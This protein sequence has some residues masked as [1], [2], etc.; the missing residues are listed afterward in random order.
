MRQEKSNGKSGHQIL[1][2]IEAGRA[3]KMLTRLV[4]TSYPNSPSEEAWK[5]MFRIFPELTEIS[6]DF[7]QQMEMCEFIAAWLRKA[8]DAGRDLRRFEWFAWQAQN[9][10]GLASDRARHNFIF[11]G[12]PSKNAITESR[13]SNSP[14]LADSEGPPAIIT[15]IEAAIFHFRR[16]FDR[17]LRC[18]NPECPTPYFFRNRKGQTYCSTECSKPA[19]RE[20]KRKWWQRE[21]SQKAKLQT[22]GRKK[23]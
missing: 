13:I 8:W 20:S 14:V 5:Q 18:A 2:I 17:V 16:E 15:S 12:D 7:K 9:E 21:R 1:G 19:Q 11:S 4:N 23:R 6:T 3:E 10:T 22:K